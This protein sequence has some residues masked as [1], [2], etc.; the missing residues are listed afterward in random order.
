MDVGDRRV[1]KVISTVSPMYQMARCANVQRN[2][3]SIRYK[4]GYLKYKLHIDQNEKVQRAMYGLTHVCA[5]D[6][7][8]GKLVPFAS[9]RVKNNSVIY[10]YV[11]R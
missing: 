9:M 2:I 7:C 1:G 3:N 11:Y 4:A 10:E 5:S 6:G 8:S